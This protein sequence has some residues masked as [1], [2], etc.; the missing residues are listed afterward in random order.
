MTTDQEHPSISYKPGWTFAW[1]ENAGL[2]LLQISCS[3]P[4]KQLDSVT[5]ADRGGYSI[6]VLPPDPFDPRWL[7]QALAD[8]EE[9]ER[10]EWLRVDGDRVFNPHVMGEPDH[11]ALNRSEWP[12]ERSE[13]VTDPARGVT[14]TADEP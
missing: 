14:L 1:K 7:L 9:H 4:E 5:G 3:A 13:S 11:I 2:W 10:R 8:I 6:F 12:N